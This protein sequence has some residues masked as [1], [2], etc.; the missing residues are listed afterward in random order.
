MKIIAINR[1][2]GSDKEEMK[3]VRETKLSY[4]VKF[5]S[6]PDQEKDIRLSKAILNNGGCEMRGCHNIRMVG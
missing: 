6:L 1:Y 4:F 3:I 5:S 2:Y